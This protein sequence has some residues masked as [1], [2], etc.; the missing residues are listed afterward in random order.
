MI[1]GVEDDVRTKPPHVELAARRVRLH[2]GEAGSGD[3]VQALALLARP[4]IVVGENAGTF[5]VP[6]RLECE[7]PSHRF[8]RC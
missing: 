2:G 7:I 8:A 3:Q 4:A 5:T 6:W 1:V